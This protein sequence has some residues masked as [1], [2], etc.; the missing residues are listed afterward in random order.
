MGKE[1]IKFKNRYKAEDAVCEAFVTLGALA[2]IDVAS[3][4]GP[5]DLDEKLQSACRESYYGDP[6]FI[7]GPGSFNH[8]ASLEHVERI[9]NPT[10]DVSERLFRYIEKKGDATKTETAE[11]AIA[12][13][14]AAHVW[15]KKAVAA[16]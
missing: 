14:T 11:E 16:T 1:T 5:A 2:G 9:F 12:V 7:G 6:H 15:L 13:I 8:A 3:G 4:K 10:F